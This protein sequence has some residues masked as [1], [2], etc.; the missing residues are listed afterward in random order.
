LPEL[1]GVKWRFWPFLILWMPLGFRATC[2]TI[3]RHIIAPIHGSARVRRGRASGRTYK[4]ETSFRY[5][6]EPHRYFFYLATI[7]LL[8]LAIDAVRGFFFRDP[9]GNCHF[10]CAVGRWCCF[11]TDLLSAFSFGCNSL[12]HLVGGN[13]TASP[14]R[15]RRGHGSTVERRHVLHLKHMEWAWVSSSGRFSDF[16]VRA[17]AM[18]WWHDVRIF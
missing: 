13:S 12:R 6:A 9:L 3:A 4:G 5:P 10:G 11:S 15:A 7:V 17:C 14:A 2:Y 18:G 16:Y 8:F 1:F